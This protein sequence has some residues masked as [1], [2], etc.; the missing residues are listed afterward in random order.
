[1]RGKYNN[2]FSLKGKLAIVTGGAGLIGKEL[3]KGL[4]EAGA[5][6]VVAEIDEDKGKKTANELK[7]QNLNA[8]FQYLDITR[9]E[10]VS[11][12]IKLIDKRYGHIDIWVNNAYPKTSDWKM[13]FEDVPFESWKKNVDMHLNG[14]FI[15]CQ[16]I[17]EYMRRKKVGVIIN[18]ASIYGIIGPDF[19]IYKNTKMTMPAAYSAI[20]GGIITFTKYLASYYG[21]Y[22]IRVNCIS[23]GG[24]YDKQS[25]LFVKRYMQKT[26]LKRM[27]NKEDIVGTGIYLASDASKYVTGHNLVV[28][29][30]WSII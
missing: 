9:K 18:L 22:G 23:P 3:S 13:K 15:C 12:L 21:K 28:D 19:S 25:D 14:Y 29:G 5:I 24:V 20:K 8:I 7:K 17:A 11:D 16:K 1:M 30:G 6:T 2:L 4:A 26:P 10:S 27:A